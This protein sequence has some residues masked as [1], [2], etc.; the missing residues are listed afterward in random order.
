MLKLHGSVSPPWTPCPLYAIDAEIP[1]LDAVGSNPISRSMFSFTYRDL[2]LVRNPLFE[3]TKARASSE[4]VDSLI[5]ERLTG[6]EPRWPSYI[7]DAGLRFSRSLTPAAG[8]NT[9][10]VAVPQTARPLAIGDLL[11]DTQAIPAV[12]RGTK[13]LL[14]PHLLKFASAP[15]G[16][17]GESALRK[18]HS[19]GSRGDYGRD[20]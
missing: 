19:V 20:C 12:I 18:A 9:S 5:L 3:V 13:G 2:K 1:K 16:F 15:Q 10:W 4:L 14:E 11:L 7:R 6:S 17:S 8:T